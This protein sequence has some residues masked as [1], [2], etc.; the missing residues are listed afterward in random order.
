M[1]RVEITRRAS[2]DLDAIAAY[3]SRDNPLAAERVDQRLR[4]A[5]EALAQNDSG[6]IGRVPA[7]YEKV[8]RGLPYIIAYE[9]VDKTTL[10][11]LRVIHMARDWPQDGW[12]DA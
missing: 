1:K 4:A 8:V 9:R 6:R 11:I 3:I 10:R 2:A 5:I 7:T 12:P